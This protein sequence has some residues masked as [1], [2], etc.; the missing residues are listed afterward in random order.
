[1]DA[2]LSAE[3]RSSA[4]IGEMSAELAGLSAQLDALGAKNA[5]VGVGVR[6]AASA[7]LKEIDRAADRLDGR[8]VRMSAD[9][10]SAAALSKATVLDAYLDRLD[11]RDINVKMDLDSA[12]F[13]TQATVTTA[14]TE[15]LTSAIG[16][17]GGGIRGAASG[18]R[19]G[20]L[21]AMVALLGPALLG[22]AAG[23][24]P[25]A[26]GI[27]TVGVAGVS[28]ATGVGLLVGAAVPLALS[29]SSLKEKG[30]ELTK[31]QERQTEAQDDLQRALR[32]GSEAEVRTARQRLAE[33]TE[34]VTR[35]QRLLASEQSRYGGV[36]GRLQK[37]ALD[38]RQAYMRAFGDSAREG[39][40]FGVELLK[41]ARGPLPA[42]GRESRETVGGIRRVFRELSDEMGGRERRSLLSILDSA[43][44][45]MSDLARAGGRFGGGLLNFV[46]EIVPGARNL[47]GY[48]SD[49]SG[50]FLSWSRTKGARDDIRDWLEEAGPMARELG[51]FLGN[52][53]EFLID[54][55]NKHGD[56]LIAAL[57]LIND[58]LDEWLGD[59]EDQKKKAREKGRGLATNFAGGWNRE[60]RRELV[61]E[62]PSV[63]ERWGEAI[64]KG[65][66]GVL[67]DM[68]E[69]DPGPAR[70]AGKDFVGGFISGMRGSFKD[71]DW[72][73][74]IR[75]VFAP[76][77]VNR[78]HPVGKFIW[79]NKALLGGFGKWLEDDWGPGMKGAMIGPFQA[80]YDRLVGNSI[81]PDT[82]N[83][84]TRL[85]NRLPGRI[86]DGLKSLPGVVG[87]A[88]K[89][90]FQNGR[91]WLGNLADSADEKT[92]DAR[93]WITRNL[94]DARDRGVE[95]LKD[96]RDEGG[97]RLASLRTR[98]GD[99]MEEAKSS[100][101]RWLTDAKEGGTKRL[102]E[103]KEAGGAAMSEAEGR[104]K[105]P[106]GRASA[107]MQQFMNNMLFGM[108]KV[109]EEAGLDLKKP[110]QYE[111]RLSGYSGAPGTSTGPR[112]A[113]AEGG[114]VSQ[115][116]GPRQS[117]LI[118]V[119]EGGHEE[120]L[121]A[122]TRDPNV[123][124]NNEHYADVAARM[125]GG[126][127]IP[128]RDLRQ[129][130][131]SMVTDDGHI[132]QHAKGG[133]IASERIAAGIARDI[134]RLAEGGMVLGVPGGNVLATF[135]QYIPGYAFSSDS[136]HK[137]VDVGQATGTPI[138]APVKGRVLQNEG[139]GVGG[140]NNAVQTSYLTKDKVQ[141]WLTSGH[142]GTGTGAPV[143]AI[144]GPDTPLG[145][146]GTSA[147]A[148]GTTPH[149][150]HQAFRTSAMYGEA[151]IF[152]PFELWR[153]VGGSTAVPS[154][155]GATIDITPLIE[156]WIKKVPDWG[157]HLPAGEAEGIAKKAREAIVERLL[158]SAPSGTDGVSAVPINASQREVA[159]WMASE[160]VKRQVPDVLPVM[161]ALVESGLKN[162]GYGDR[163]SL[164]Y[165][166]ERPSQGWGTAEQIMN[167]EYALD[168]F[169]DVAE[170]MRR[171][172]SWTDAGA[173]GNWAQDVQ[174]SA[175]PDR[176]AGAYPQA[177][178]LV[179]AP[180]E[181]YT[182]GGIA[183]SPHLAWVAEKGPE[184]FMPLDRPD[185][186]RRFMDMLRDMAPR[187]FDDEETR[188]RHERMGSLAVRT[189]R[190][191]DGIERDAEA[192]AREL[193][194]LRQEMV[195][196]LREQT[197][198]LK[199]TLE[200]E[201][202]QRLKV[203]LENVEDLLEMALRV[204]DSPAG[205]DGHARRNAAEYERLLSRLGGS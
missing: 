155:A 110:G 73:K 21:L 159:G 147:D 136:R 106:V 29:L 64:G 160:A 13:V 157:E 131:R 188:T 17:G 20:G 175:Y 105:N 109:I 24:G 9:L 148:A 142:L 139:P 43:S 31:A 84:A 104:Y 2:V 163:D 199:E 192:A 196:E 57:D 38:L 168:K 178:G 121:V 203:A 58:T 108:A 86:G 169:L 14:A 204:Q 34:E 12:G 80:I 70:E 71:F 112:R 62:A 145:R 89:D 83:E 69:T 1:M 130:P 195:R 26:A 176:Y 165:F 41:L 10:D 150:H 129:W 118:E 179:G 185:T 5:E 182:N 167:P 115:H 154:G 82:V 39:G 23:A 170:E 116:F 156:K 172:V 6:D 66:G 65:L 59:D 194:T 126:A 63:G 174:R 94:G 67:R 152:D 200:R 93:K 186:A 33:A 96:L 30:E 3:N 61:Q 166:Q 56:E 149:V 51:R 125:L 90:A 45:I 81:I 47:S 25:A 85:F 8:D 79:D 180:P 101:L 137:G 75:N 132:H 198:E 97:E 42:L 114:I 153:M 158:A 191:G 92:G 54:F 144:V 134:L 127:F 52:A 103:L 140:Y 107:D 44:D 102:D 60:I 201:L 76:P 16:G 181:G 138:Y 177:R 135:Q 123:R 7:D 164:G 111:P 77:K 32:G 49:I 193:R 40:E 187:G 36:V 74:F 184:F 133:V 120:V 183:L 91:K 205:R 143:G 197:G 19:A 190:A 128:E 46:A 173:L 146:I 189:A 117:K 18:I 78:D 119:G 50:D 122:I 11:G 151:N 35:A 171:A 53:V 15:G 124:P 88:F 113:M 72:D 87:G 161:T 100:I 162:L 99:R 37:E 98:A 48:L 4:A 22:A 141:V 95:F 55:G 28:A 202:R 68:F 27:A